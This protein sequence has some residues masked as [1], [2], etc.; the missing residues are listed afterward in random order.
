[1]PVAMAAIAVVLK[2]TFGAAR[3]DRVD[4]A[5]SSRRYTERFGVG[6]VRVRSVDM[7]SVGRRVSRSYSWSIIL[8]RHQMYS[9]PSVLLLS[10][11]RILYPEERP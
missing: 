4:I 2:G 9:R 1:M 5:W 11:T 3:V 10:N 8:C 7:A 6:V